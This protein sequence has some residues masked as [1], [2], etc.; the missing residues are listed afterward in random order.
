MLPALKNANLA[1]SFLLELG[2]LV[3]FGYW[4]FQTG[5]G[6]PLQLLQGLGAPALMVLVWGVFLAPTSARRLPDPA[7][8]GLALL[9]FGLAALSLVAAHQGTL[10]GVFG[11]LAVLNAALAAWWH[12]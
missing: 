10:A 9:I 8:R 1:L 7:R 5:A 6:L 12:Q 3:A 11:V 4:G 2:A